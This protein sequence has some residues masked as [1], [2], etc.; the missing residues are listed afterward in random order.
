M[1]ET[2]EF[3][4]KHKGSGAV[5]DAN[6]LLVYAVG[7]YDREMLRR[8]HHTKQFAE[9]F[10]WIESLILKWFGKIHTTPNIL[11]EV[12][13]LGSGLGREFYDE[14]KRVVAPLVEI[15]CQSATAAEDR[16][17]REVGL[18]DSVIPGS[19]RH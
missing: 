17:F 16:K 4:R 12:S 1:N 15:H 10:E 18:T 14:F 5:L 19:R 7:R 2:E 3:L 13:N 9:D 6:L 11:T 8:F